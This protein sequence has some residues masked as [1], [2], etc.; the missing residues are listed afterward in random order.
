MLLSHDQIL[1]GGNR[2]AGQLPQTLANPDLE[3]LDLRCLLAPC[4]AESCA[5]T[6]HFS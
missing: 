2:F 5:A 6:V 3:R 4:A 1:L